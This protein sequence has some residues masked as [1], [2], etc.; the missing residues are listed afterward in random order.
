MSIVS[1]IFRY[2]LLF[3]PLVLGFS[4]SRM[5]PV[6]KESGAQ[7]AYRPPSTAFGIVWTI[8][9]ILLGI[10]MW[11]SY[12]HHATPPVATLF[13]FLLVLLNL[14]QYF[15][16]CQRQKQAA[17][18]CL[19]LSVATTIM[20]MGYV[21]DRYISLLL[22]PFLTWIVFASKMNADIIQIESSRAVLLQKSI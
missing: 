10:S 1:S 19:L 15:F 8:L 5:C 16:S 2:S 20:I 22:S 3:V 13:V 11:R 21:Q 17:L 7:L 9:Y 18:Y 14:W 12:Q 6:G 4:V